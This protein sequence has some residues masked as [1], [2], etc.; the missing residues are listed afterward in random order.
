MIRPGTAAAAASRRLVEGCAKEMKPLELGHLWCDYEDIGVLLEE[1]AKVET[2]VR[3]VSL[4]DVDLEWWLSP[5]G[6]KYW[7]VLLDAINRRKVHVERIFVY[8]EWTEQLDALA[9]EQR[10]DGVHVLKVD[11]RDLPPRLHVDM[12]IW[13][14]HCGY[15]TKLN[16]LV[17]GQ[18]HFFTYQR[19]DVRLQIGLYDQIYSFATD[20]SGGS[21]S[22]VLHEPFGV[23]AKNA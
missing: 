15:E 12:I 17:G 4:Q 14:E 19:E 11:R 21:G 2:S 7:Q 23:R 3:S 16:D 20:L 10:A 8:S 1:A 5:L 22:C 13:D 18:R 9:E 6:R